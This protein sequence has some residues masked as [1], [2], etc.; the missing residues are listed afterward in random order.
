MLVIE[1]RSVV[2]IGRF[3]RK[4]RRGACLGEMLGVERLAVKVRQRRPVG[5]DLDG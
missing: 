3:N 2:L 5:L 1:V 4:N